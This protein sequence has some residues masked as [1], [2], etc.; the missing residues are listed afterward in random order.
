VFPETDFKYYLDAHLAE[1]SRRRAA[2]GVHENLAARDKRD[3]QRAAA[4]LM[5]A[6]GAKVINNSQMTSEQTSGTILVDIK[7]RMADR[8]KSRR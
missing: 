4:P 6:L 8:L 5:I 2:D 7:K 3:S 1:R